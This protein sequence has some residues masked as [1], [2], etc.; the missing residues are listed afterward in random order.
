M[1][2][3]ESMPRPEI[4]LVADTV[5]REKNIDKE[6]VF[7]AMEVAIQKGARSKY[8]AEHDIRA[9]ID[10]KSG[11]ISLSRYREVVDDDAVIENEAAQLPLSLAKKY[12]ADAKVGDFLIDALPPL[13]FR[14]SRSTLHNFSTT[15]K[16]SSRFSVIGDTSCC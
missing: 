1:E 4:I 15:C 7:V 14:L 12:K 10:R 2:N 5:A 3:I 8:G 6:D 9:K 16:N 13:D 11:A